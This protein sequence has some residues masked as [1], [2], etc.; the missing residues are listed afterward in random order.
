L[1]SGLFAAAENFF[2]AGPART[3]NFSRNLHREAPY[4]CFVE[5]K[6]LQTNSETA[7][8]RDADATSDPTI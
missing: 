6:P 4:A 7:L 3:K 8:Q 5:T 2:C 1:R